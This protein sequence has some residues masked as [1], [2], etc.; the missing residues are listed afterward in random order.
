MDEEKIGL[1]KAHAQKDKT[2]ERL[3]NKVNEE[4]KSWFF[5]LIPNNATAYTIG[6]ILLFLLLY[7]KVDTIS[8]SI[9]SLCVYDCTSE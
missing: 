3:N 2:I 4:N 5:T 6:F 1:Y 9:D 8:I 7:S